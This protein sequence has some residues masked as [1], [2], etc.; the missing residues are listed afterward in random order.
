MNRVLG[1]LQ[2]AL[3]DKARWPLYAIV[4]IGLLLVVG[5]GCG[6][7]TETSPV[8]A[9]STDAAS[10]LAGTPSRASSGAASTQPSAVSP[11]RAGARS[12]S[13]TRGPAGTPITPTERSTAI[14]PTD[15]SVARC[16]IDRLPPEA[17]RTVALVQSGGPFPYP[18]NDGVA[19][20]NAERLLP[21]RAEGYYREY[22]V[23]TPGSPDRGARRVVTGGDPKTNL[24]LWYYTGDHYDSFCEITGLP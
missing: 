17:R 11:G 23:P 13:P 24:P 16:D 4:V 9:A 14:T 15:R 20:R 2:R 7:S 8:A 10:P 1:P 6:P 3:A 5:R 18:R 21:G 22:T 12:T 19:F